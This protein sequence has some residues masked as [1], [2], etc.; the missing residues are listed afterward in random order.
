[1]DKW[2]Q[3]LH[4]VIKAKA[5][6]TGELAMRALAKKS[7]Y[8]VIIASDTSMNHLQSIQERLQYYQIPSIVTLTKTQLSQLTGMK[9]VV[10]IAITN[11]NLAKTLKEKEPFHEKT[12]DH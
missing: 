6:L 5:Y 10:M 12:S 7:V 3:Q 9:Q 8:Y 1:M 11:L 2:L 4:F